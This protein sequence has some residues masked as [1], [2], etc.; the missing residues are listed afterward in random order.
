MTFTIRPATP[1]DAAAIAVV[2]APYVEGATSFEA[3]PPDDAEMRRRIITT[4]ASMP[5]L[6]AEEAAT[7]LGYAYADPFRKRDAYAWSCEV[8]VYLAASAHRRGIGRALYDRL[9]SILR[10]LGYLAAFA[11]ITLP[12]EA[13]VGFH[14][15]LGFEPIGTYPRVGF[16]LGRF[17][18]VGWWHLRLAESDG[19]PDP[20]RPYRP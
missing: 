5:W 20:P 11:G 12:N 6:V 8:S 16:K 7:I 14:E 2:Y 19:A 18:D 17:W 4:L 9:L 3:T 1:D 15:A 10:D 13:S